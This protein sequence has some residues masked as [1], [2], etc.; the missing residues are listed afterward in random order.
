MKYVKPGN[1]TKLKGKD[2]Y[3]F[4]YKMM[5]GNLS[6]I[7]INELANK[8]RIIRDINYGTMKELENDMESSMEFPKVP[9]DV[10]KQFIDAVFVAS[11]N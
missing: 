7:R 8:W 5:D 6:A 11:L 2:L 1:I 9:G 3:Y 4:F 10:A